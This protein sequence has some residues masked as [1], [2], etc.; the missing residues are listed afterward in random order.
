M[1]LR[2][3][4]NPHG[5]F[6][7]SSVVGLRSDVAWPRLSVDRS[8]GG[9]ARKRAHPYMSLVPGRCHARTWIHA[10]DKGKHGPQ[11]AV[12]ILEPRHTHLFRGYLVGMDP[13]KGRLS[14]VLCSMPQHFLNPWTG[15]P[16]LRTAHSDDI[17]NNA[18]A[19]LRATLRRT[20][21]TL[22]SPFKVLPV[23]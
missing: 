18:E 4:M 13:H 10:C 5:F 3:G 1:T 21:R 23:F 11:L 9:K 2:Q 12:G 19:F 22:E 17:W 20:T 15:Y 7:L 16:W 14:L 8:G 6:R